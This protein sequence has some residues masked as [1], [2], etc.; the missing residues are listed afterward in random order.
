MLMHIQGVFFLTGPLLNV[1]V[2]KIK[3]PTLSRF[4]VGL[5]WVRLICFEFIHC[6][7]YAGL[8]NLSTV[9]QQNQ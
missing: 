1:Y 9:E 6:G 5:V 8:L 2:K 4:K 7:I 3:L